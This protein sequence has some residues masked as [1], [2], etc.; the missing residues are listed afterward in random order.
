MQF[1]G[2][3]VNRSGLYERSEGLLFPQTLD[4]HLV[5][6]TTTTTEITAQRRQNGALLRPLPSKS[7][8]GELFSHARCRQIRGYKSQNRVWKKLGLGFLRKMNGNSV[9]WLSSV[10]FLMILKNVKKTR[11]F[12]SKF[13]APFGGDF[14]LPLG[15]T[16]IAVTDNKVT[17]LVPAAGARSRKSMFFNCKS[18]FANQFCLSH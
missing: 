14:F 4:F 10:F 1:W 17:N 7:A 9:Y 13:F 12:V 11:I 6:T 8:F 16:K 18:T 2:F 5:L 3:G 15:C